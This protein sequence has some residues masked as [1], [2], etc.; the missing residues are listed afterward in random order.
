MFAFAII[1]LLICNPI[2]ASICD[3]NPICVSI[4][5][6]FV[7]LLAI[8]NLCFY[9]QSYLYFYLQSSLCAQPG[10][11]AQFISNV[12]RRCTINPV[13]VQS[14][15]CQKPD[16]NHAIIPSIPQL[17]RKKHT[18]WIEDPVAPCG[19]ANG[20][21]AFQTSQPN[22]CSSPLTLLL[23]QALADTNSK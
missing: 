16:K 1:V 22:R 14:S 15:S 13:I 18:D 4:G 8:N 11:R 19:Q 17:W 12:F 23:L 2:C 7:F 20:L 6:L 3:C 21:E 5:I 9:L 10:S